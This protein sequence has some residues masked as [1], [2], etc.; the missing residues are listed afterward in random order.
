[1]NQ[2]NAFTEIDK[3]SS[4]WQK[5]EAHLAVR[6][7]SARTK[8]E[9]S[10]PESETQKLRGEIAQIRSLMRLADEPPPVL[11]SPAAGA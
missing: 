7:E 6:L 9:K 5:V 10:M 3:F 4:T 11:E 8:L 1:M 2:E